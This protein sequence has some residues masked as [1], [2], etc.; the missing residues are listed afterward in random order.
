MIST[1]ILWGFFRSEYMLNLTSPFD[2]Q[3]YWMTYQ[4]EITNG[5]LY[6]E[7]QW[8]HMWYIN[9]YSENSWNKTKRGGPKHFL[10]NTN[11]MFHRGPIQKALS[12]LFEMFKLTSPTLSNTVWQDNMLLKMKIYNM[13]LK[14]DAV[15]NNQ[16]LFASILSYRNKNTL[17]FSC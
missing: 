9:L 13:K 3:L 2:I 4:P 10:D 15:P 16:N 11:G 17:A 7:I 1:I 12:Y 6:N 5:I 14:N 8:E